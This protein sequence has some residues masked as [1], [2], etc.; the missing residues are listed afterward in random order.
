MLQELSKEL[1]LHTMTEG[2]GI[3]GPLTGQY[4]S[5]KFIFSRSRVFA[6]GAGYHRF[7]ALPP[8]VLQHGSYLPPPRLRP[9]LSGSLFALQL[10]Q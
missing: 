6:E 7:S 9:I 1:G 2:F 10:S 8:T 4:V 3:A 5:W